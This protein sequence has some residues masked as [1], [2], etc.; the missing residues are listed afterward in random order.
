MS[1]RILASSEEEL[2]AIGSTIAESLK[3]GDIIYLDG[4]LGAGKTTLVRGI[5]K[6]MGYKGIVPSPTYTL[7][8]L[9]EVGN[10]SVAHFDLYRL[11]NPREL[12]E[13]GMRDYLD[14][15]TILLIEWPER[16]LGALPRPTLCII[17]RY[18]NEGREIQLSSGVGSDFQFPPS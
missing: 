15:S 9:Y 11:Q 7:L 12:E 4:E 13:I 18:A 17:L 6:G 8:E 16:G 14:G 5:L 1:K 2:A 3:P 10:Y